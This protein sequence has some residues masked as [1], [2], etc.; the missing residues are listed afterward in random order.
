[1]SE[2]QNSSPSFFARYPQ[3]AIEHINDITMTSTDEESNSMVA[4]KANSNPRRAPHPK[5]IIV[6]VLEISMP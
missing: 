1:L 4:A 6:S 5:R 2:Y 3:I